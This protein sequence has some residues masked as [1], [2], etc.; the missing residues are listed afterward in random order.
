VGTTRNVELIVVAIIAVLVVAVVAWMLVRRSSARTEA[1][2]EEATQ[3]R[4]LAEVARLEA[5]AKAAAAEEQAARARKEQFLAEHQHIE[6]QAA[7]ETV[8]DLERQADEIDPDVD[9]AAE[10]RDDVDVDEG[11]QPRSTT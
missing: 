11:S 8:V 5:D 10:E 7:H 2:R 4:D 9:L 1:R 3:H 6:A